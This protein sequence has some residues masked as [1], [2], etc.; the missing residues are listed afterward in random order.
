VAEGWPI[1]IK[2]FRQR[3]YLAD[4]DEPR[5]SSR[6]QL[7]KESYVSALAQAAKAKLSEDRHFFFFEDTSVN[8][9]A[10]AQDGGE[11]PGVDIKFWMENQTLHELNRE[12]GASEESRLACVRSDVVLHIPQ[13]Y[14]KR[15]K[16]ESD[17]LVFTGIQEGHITEREFT[18]ETNIV[19]PW[20]DNRTFNKW[21]CPRGYSVPIGTLPILDADKVDFRRKSLSAM[22]EFLEEKGVLTP[23]VR[24][25]QFPFDNLSSL[26]LCGYTCAGKTTASQY[27]TRHSEY[28]HIEASDFMYVSYYYR[29]DVNEVISIADFAE[30]ALKDK[31]EIAAEKIAEY[32]EGGPRIPFVI[33]GFRDPMEIEYIQDRLSILG[34][35]CRVAFIDCEQPK[36]FQRMTERQRQGDQLDFKEFRERDKQQQRMGLDRIQ[37]LPEAV[38]WKNEGTIEEYYELVRNEVPTCGKEILVEKLLSAAYCLEGVKLEDTILLS[39]LSVWEGA[40]S[41]RYYTTSEIANLINGRF[42]E[43]VKHK[44][45]VSRYFNQDFYAYFEMTMRKEGA[46]RK[47]RL[48]NTGVSKAIQRLRDL[49]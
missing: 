22:F 10:L 47:Y 35:H 9:P 29:H 21:F 31:P 15:W 48:S 46:L 8:I 19:Y 45:N 43:S 41:G 26:I 42:V 33:S 5:I 40:E 13:F 34:I 1:T 44:D 2:G 16:I 28:L 12:L 39:L 38:E 25:R 17:Y 32:I 3:T 30:M 6:E 36:R 7:L 11:F 27:I 20:L 18:F 49:S 37:E 24:Q 4:Y 14:K 23:Q